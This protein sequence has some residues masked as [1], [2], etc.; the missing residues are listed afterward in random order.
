MVQRKI[1]QEMR[2]RSWGRVV[3]VLTRV[4]REVFPEKV[5]LSREGAFEEGEGDLEI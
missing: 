5:R 4:V 2:I 1:K 3:A